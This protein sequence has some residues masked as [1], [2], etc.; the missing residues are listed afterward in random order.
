[1]KRLTVLVATHKKYKF[2]RVEYY[3]PIQVGCVN[4]NLELGILRD[5]LV[6]I[7]QAKTLLFVSSPLSIGL[8][9]MAFL[10]KMIMSA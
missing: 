5:D 6:K 2:P 8:G 4:T 3:I 1:M 10:R 7:S 9:K